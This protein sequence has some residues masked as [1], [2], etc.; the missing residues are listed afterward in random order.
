MRTHSAN[1]FY[2]RKVFNRPLP[3]KPQKHLRRR[4]FINYFC[5]NEK[6][7]ELFETKFCYSTSD[8]KKRFKLYRE[9][10]NLNL[11][12]MKK[13][14]SCAAILFAVALVGCSKSNKEEAADAATDTVSATEGVTNQVIPVGAV[15][16][17]G[18]LV[19]ADGNVIATVVDGNFVDAQ[20][21]VVGTVEAVEANVAAAK[22]SV[23]DAV[24]NAVDKAKDAVDAAKDKAG[25]VVEN[26]KEAGQNAVNNVKEAGQNAVDKTKDAVDKAKNAV[27]DKLNEAGNALKK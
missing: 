26:V 16:E 1:P 3:E 25:D 24:D 15:I 20:G 23:G 9:K 2:G 18:Q 22:E 14:I 10:I 13:L 6:K 7:C 19:D 12:T 4:Y 8:A 21:N 17:E 27:G 5:A 11:S